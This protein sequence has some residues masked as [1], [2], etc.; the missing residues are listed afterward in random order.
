M[1]LKGTLRNLLV[2]GQF[3][4]IAEL[5]QTR[6]RVLASLVSLTYDH[7]QLVAWRAVEAV[8]IA[9]SRISVDD[10]GFVREHLRRLLWLISEESGGV[11]WRAPEAMAEIVRRQPR[12]YADY[13]P[14]VVYL[15]EN[16]EKEDLEH[17]RS[18]TLRAIGRLA[19][20]AGEHIPTVLPPVLASLR[21]PDPQ[22][23]GMAVWCLAQLG[24]LKAVAD[25][26]MLAADS[27]PVVLYED[28]QLSSTTVS[29]I[30][31]RALDA[32]STGG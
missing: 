1:S 30:V 24:E 22:T 16:I 4:H 31:R 26:P 28:G 2:A 11:C 6:K 17:L 18:G 21:E 27:G 9:A 23:R 19:P 12:Q 10:P 25:D 20:I 7:E 15:I 32:R 29:A 5:A 8:G 14:I 3:E 13:I